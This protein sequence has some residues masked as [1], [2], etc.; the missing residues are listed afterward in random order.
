M[1]SADGNYDHTK[2]WRRDPQPGPR[3]DYMGPFSTLEEEL[4]LRAKLAPT[5]PAVQLADIVRPQIPQV[6]LF[7][8]KYGYRV[9]QIGIAD[10]MNVD[11]LFLDPGNQN[12]AADAGWQGT[13]RF[14]QQG[15]SW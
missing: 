14:A 7:R 5:I 6:M 13:S 1:N 15:G 9:R 8:P 12:G 4:T 3:Y 2:P 11:E 10:L